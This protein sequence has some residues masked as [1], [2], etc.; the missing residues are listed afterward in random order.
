MSKAKYSQEGSGHFGLVLK[1]YAHFT[2]PIR[3]YPDL[4]IHRIMSDF[5]ECRNS[6]EVTSRYQKFVYHSA[7][8]STACELKAVT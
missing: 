3:R 4:S 5:L 6:A 8:Q 7:N 1:D 2:S